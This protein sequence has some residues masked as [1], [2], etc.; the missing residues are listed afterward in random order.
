MKLDNTGWPR[1]TALEIAKPK[2]GKQVGYIH[3]LK[4]VPEYAARSPA[5]LNFL[6]GMLKS[7]PILS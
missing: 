7:L 3:R 1:T 5:D 6:K 4:T 2:A